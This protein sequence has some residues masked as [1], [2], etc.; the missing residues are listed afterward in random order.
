VRR[1]AL[2]SCV[3]LAA[4][5]QRAA[6]ASCV[7]LAAPP[8]QVALALCV[9][10]AA[11]QG[12]GGEGRQ[13]VVPTAPAVAPPPAP[14]RAPSAGPIEP[15]FE[16]TI[17]S[18]LACV[19]IGGRVHCGSL[20][21]ERPLVAEAPL[22]GVEGAVSVA[23]GRGYA[24]SFGCVATQRGGV[25]CFGHNAYGQLG[26]GLRAEESDVP[27]PVK[28]LSGARRVFAGDGHVCALLEDGG[29]R[30]WGFNSQGQV[31]SPTS[32]E[33]AAR[34]LVMPAEEVGA[35]KG[36][37]R[38]AL[39]RSATCALVDRGDLLCWGDAAT[40]GPP[41]HHA[42]LR[43]PRRV[44]DTAGLAELDASEGGFC[45]VRAGEVLCWGDVSQLFDA[46]YNVPGPRSVGVTRA[47]RVR[48]GQQHA[49][50]LHDDGQVSCWGL[51]MNGELGRATT[52][53]GYERFG[54]QIVEGLPPAVDLAVG[55]SLSCAIT[56]KGEAY[57]WGRW[58]FA[59][60][61]EPRKEV[62][63]VKVPVLE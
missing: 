30:C 53:G 31:G 41:P 51:N 29:V 35:A 14:P 37:S 21:S 49:C 12:A 48:L 4:S 55:G 3:G 22:A 47:R 57:C 9:A 16:L 13:V 44:A 56:A 27:V 5:V 6:L 33:P 11:C 25:L 36:A 43:R 61:K 39:S 58:P 45:G 62:K 10:L 26:A 52:P 1:A 28:G 40:P 42:H 2:G 63:P 18:F 32:Y 46:A 60:E 17:N 15:P 7:V 24:R 59:G 20:D 23:L 8:R 38:L 19:R 50:A 54:P 34:E